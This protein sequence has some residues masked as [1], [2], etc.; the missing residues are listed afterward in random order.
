MSLDYSFDIATSLA[1]A[2][3]MRTFL[4]RLGLP[5]NPDDDCT[6]STPHFHASVGP[7]SRDFSEHML[8]N[9]GFRPDAYFVFRSWAAADIE[10]RAEIVCGTLAICQAVPGDAVM[11]FNGEIVLYMRKAGVLYVNSTYW[12]GDYSLFTPP[13]EVKAYKVLGT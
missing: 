12:E 11:L 6:V 13:Y 2:N 7:M 10:A 9:V 3:L 5:R 4:L 1:P 8:E